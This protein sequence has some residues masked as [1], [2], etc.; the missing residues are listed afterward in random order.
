MNIL[1][2]TD[3]IA[4]YLREDGTWQVPPNT[5]YTSLKNPYSL[6]I[7][8]N[9]TTL[10]NGTYDGS[11]AKTVNITPGSIGAAASSHT[12][13]YLPLAGGTMNKDAT[14]KIP[15][16]NEIYLFIRESSAKY[17]RKSTTYIAFLQT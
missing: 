3:N 1:P 13:N 6:T 5:T 7:Q 17:Q 2:M 9:G 12:H 10:T 16:T 14:I 4:E 11:T 15:I 8:G